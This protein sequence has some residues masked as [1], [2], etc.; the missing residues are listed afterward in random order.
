MQWY[1]TIFQVYILTLSFWCNKSKIIDANTFF[2]I[3]FAKNLCRDHIWTHTRFSMRPSMKVALKATGHTGLKGWPSTSQTWPWSLCRENFL[4]NVK[5]NY[6]C[7]RFNKLFD[8]NTNIIL[9]INHL[10]PM[11]SHSHWSMSKWI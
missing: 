8:K 6:W 1:L 11:Y 10:L 7:L 5:K 4:T 9:Q 2:F 3:S